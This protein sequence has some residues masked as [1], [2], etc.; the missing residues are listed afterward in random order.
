MNFQRTRN[1]TVTINQQCIRAWVEHLFSRENWILD[2]TWMLNCYFFSFQQHK[3][4]VP[5]FHG[6][7][8]RWTDCATQIYRIFFLK[9]N[10]NVVIQLFL[11]LRV[12]NFVYCY[13]YIY[14]E[15]RISFFER[16]KNN[17]EDRFFS[18]DC[19]CRRIHYSFVGDFGVKLEAN[20]NLAAAVNEHEFQCQREFRI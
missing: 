13:K 17:G 15:N 2:T 12:G 9:T 4:V 8:S 20:V 7:F 16:N 10:Y 14:I 1:I 11:Q 19:R 5:H 18:E 6:F 3:N